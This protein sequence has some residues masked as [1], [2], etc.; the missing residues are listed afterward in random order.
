VSRCH[1]SDVCSLG[2]ASPFNLL[3]E[4]KSLKTAALGK[5]TLTRVDCLSLVVASQGGNL[6]EA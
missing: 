3:A 2:R 4:L 5:F 6:A 1:P